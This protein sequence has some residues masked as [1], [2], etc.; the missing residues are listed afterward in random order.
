MPEET[1][2][3]EEQPTMLSFTEAAERLVADGIAQSMTAEGLR[4]LARE[5]ASGWPI[6]PADYR[7]VGK[8]RMLP[9]ELLVPYMQARR[10]GRGPDKTKQRNVPAKKVGRARKPQGGPV[11]TTTDPRS[12]L[13][14]F[15]MDGKEHSPT[16]SDRA[17]QRIDAYRAGVLHSFADEVE[18]M[19][20][21]P[22]DPAHDAHV[23]GYNSALEHV[24]AELRRRAAEPEAQDG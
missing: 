2:Q 6:G 8:T 20:V 21:G 15:A 10:R 3:G 17:S 24:V 5:P 7:V 4:K 12:D 19:K 13:Y 18:G 14:A 11:T 16:N 22:E 9:Y 1:P 23:R